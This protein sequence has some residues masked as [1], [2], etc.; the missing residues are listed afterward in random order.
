MAAEDAIR[1]G[2][3][4]VSTLKEPYRL[5]GKKKKPWVM[6]LPNSLTGNCLM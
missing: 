2:W 6:K 1:N 3:F 4:Q 5:E